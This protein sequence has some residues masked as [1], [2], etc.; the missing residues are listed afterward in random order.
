MARS[1]FV[2]A[3]LV[4]ACDPSSLDG[5]DPDSFPGYVPVFTV[6]LDSTDGVDKPRDLEFHPSR[7]NEL[8]VVNRGTED[9]GSDVLI[10]TDAG[11][12]AQ[13]VDVRQD[14]NAWHFM[15]TTTAMAFSPDND[16]WATTPEV[17]DANHS[18]GT[19]TG[20]SLWSSDLDVFAQPSG[21]NGSHLD[22]LHGSPNSMGIAHDV[23]NAF[24]VFDGYHSEIVW[25]DFVE[26]HGPGNDDH[27]DA[28]VHRY[29]SLPIERL[30][31][32]PSGMVVDHASDWLYI[33]DP[34]NS[35]ILR[36]DVTSGTKQSE[37]PLINE[38][39]AEHWQMTDE[40]WEVF[41]SE[42][43]T[44]PTGIAVDATQLYVTDNTTNEIIIFDL[45]TG[46]E[47]GRIQTNAIGLNG[48]EIDADG[49]IWYIDGKGHQVV[50]IDRG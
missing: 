31:K 18:G 1:L 35:Q 21:G 40:V 41:A 38:M 43:V 46:E 48:I 37:A 45:V 26:D 34:G 13:S 19:F 5:D 20:P 9:T 11:L 47:K 10:V 12:A 44:T 30:N 28:L 25:Y 23:D 27:S 4:S 29:S 39:L 17:T 42:S 32:V 16:N 7:A 49:L 8:W 22:M 24:W 3:L 14:G 15:N 36:M 6:V 33:C 50:R 2:L